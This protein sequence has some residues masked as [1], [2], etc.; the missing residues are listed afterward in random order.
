MGKRACLRLPPTARARGRGPFCPAVRG[1]G[2]GGSN[3]LH[4]FFSLVEVSH[5]FSLAAIRSFLVPVVSFGRNLF[6]CWLLLFMV[7]I[8]GGENNAWE[9]K[10]MFIVQI[11]VFWRQGFIALASLLK[12]AWSWR[13]LGTFGVYM[14]Y[15]ACSFE[16]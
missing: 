2:A 7:I 13:W 6:V 15:I 9:W 10:Q 11:P 1:G 12:L 16:P 4:V 5:T 3:V 14:V 8:K